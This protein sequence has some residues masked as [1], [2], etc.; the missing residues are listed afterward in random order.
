MWNYPDYSTGVQ[1]TVNTLNLGHYDPLVQ[2]LQQGLDAATLNLMPGVQDALASWS[3]GHYN[4]FVNAGVFYLEI[5]LFDIHLLQ[6]SNP[7]TVDS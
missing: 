3:G 1:N 2:G 7:L 6:I 4:E 5:V